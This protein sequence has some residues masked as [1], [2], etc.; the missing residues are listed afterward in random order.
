MSNSVTAPHSRIWSPRLPTE[1][2]LTS[3]LWIAAICTFGI[4][5]VLTT[6]VFIG[7]GLAAEGHPVAAAGIDALGLWILIPWKLAVLWIFRR[8]YR[9][10]PDSWSA[11]VPL[12]LSLLGTLLVVWNT[13]SSLTGAY[14]TL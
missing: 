6:V 8:I 14:L 12:G 13:Y 11:G 9:A 7:M 1:L 2:S 4:G 5:D 10:V 3:G